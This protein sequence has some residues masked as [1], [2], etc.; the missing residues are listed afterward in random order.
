[1]L[2]DVMAAVHIAGHNSP[3]ILGQYEAQNAVTETPQIKRRT[4]L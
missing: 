4:P 3:Q 2:K 1:M